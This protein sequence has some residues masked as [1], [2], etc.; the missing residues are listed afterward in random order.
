MYS[1]APLPTTV[2]ELK[3]RLSVRL[4]HSIYMSRL[5][6]LR[7]TKRHPNRKQSMAE[8]QLRQL[9]GS[10]ETLILELN[11]DRT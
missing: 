1:T 2:G 4:G 6:A 7:A 10:I 3:A 11:T 8:V 9:I 5:V